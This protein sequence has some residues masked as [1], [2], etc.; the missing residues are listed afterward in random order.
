MWE[1]TDERLAL[2]ELLVSGALKKR[3]A[4]T[5]VFDVLAELPWTRVTGRRDEIGL[6]EE[7]RHELTALLERVWPEWGDALAELTARGL[8]PTPDGW[9]KLEDARRAEG[10]PALPELINR[11]TAA[12]LAAPHSK[13]TLTE[14]RRATLGDA[15]ATHDG[16]VRLRPPP[17]LLVRTERGLVD[18]SAVAGVL[19]EV[20][21]PERAFL[22]SIVFEGAV[23]ALLLIENLGAWRDLA[24]PD[25]LLLAHVP[26]WDTAT[27]AHLLEHFTNI[28]VVH[29]GDLDPNGVRILMHLRERRPDLIW[30][31]P[32]FWV[33]FVESHGQRG[34]WPDD[35][36]LGWAPELVRA[37]AE[38]ELWLEQERIVLDPR[39]RRDLEGLVGAG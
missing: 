27:V 33:E 5:A 20:A 14:R 13:A 6:V 34:I 31:V 17:G 28:P 22:D 39:V 35:L 11:R 9:G 21:I 7:H 26:G 10:L 19:G 23:R 1:T 4:Q 36:D 30:F 16:T 2:L 37:L 29:F 3:R 24:A 8:P 25:G 38:R 32:S 18:L 15:E 12:A